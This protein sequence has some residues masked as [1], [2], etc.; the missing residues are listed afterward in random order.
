MAACA[1][2]TMRS[3]PRSRFETSEE[4]DADAAR[5][6]AMVSRTVAGEPSKKSGILARVAPLASRR[7]RSRCGP[8]SHEGSQGRPVTR[9]LLDTNIISN[10]VKPR[11]SEALIAW[12]EHR[13]D[14][15]LFIASL[16]L[17]EIRRGLVEKPATAP[18]PS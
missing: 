16:T 6:R 14:E 8:P 3:K 4:N 13:D 7:R 9:Y 1:P 11:P 15:D 10:V 2:I 12:M 5:I 18:L 17:A